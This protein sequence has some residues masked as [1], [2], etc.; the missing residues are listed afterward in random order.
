MAVMEQRFR[1]P[2]MKLDLRSVCDSFPWYL[3]VCVRC[4]LNYILV[5]SRKLLGL[6]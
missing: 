3:S 1:S 2:R 6:T 4:V 5:P